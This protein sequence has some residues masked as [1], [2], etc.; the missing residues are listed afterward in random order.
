MRDVAL[1]SFAQS[2]C[3]AADRRHDMA[4]ILLPVMREALDN[5]GIDRS[6]V[7]FFTSGSHDFYEGRTFAYIESLDA[8][9]AW[10]PISESH[11]EM[12][13]AWALY[14]AWAWLQLGEG[15]IA[16]VYGV[17]RGSLVQNL[18]A[19]TSAQLDPYYLAPLRPH[20][21][22]LAA[23]QAAA[24]IDSGALDEQRMA[25]VVAR[26]LAAAVDN[27]AAQISRNVSVQDL[28]AAPYIATPLRAHD[29]GPIGDASAVAVLAAGDAARRLTTRPAW[30]RG[31]D[32]RMD[33][34]YPGARDLTRL[35]T[36]ARAA[37]RAAELAGFSARDVD[38]AELHTEY[39][40]QEPLLVDTLEL[41]GTEVNPGGGPLT[42]RPATATGLIR[43]GEAAQHILT[44]RADRTLAH[45]TSGPALQ[46]NL[47]CLLEGDR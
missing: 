9:G 37:A 46:Q 26:S 27:P 7:D 44:G 16:V 14:E 13:A 41:T 1:V 6:E 23:L 5:A 25:E 21:D 47:I 45:A 28:L 43:I 36:V 30:I 29:V 11:V 20:Q 18:D 32:H 42:G 19:V 33:T 24:L 3:A 22:A 12:D 15:D 40:Y 39:S 2:P 34:H 8:V 17:G 31:A 35:D 10:P 4:E 38:V